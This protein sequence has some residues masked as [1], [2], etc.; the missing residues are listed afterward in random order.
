MPTVFSTN[1]TRIARPDQAVTLGA[2]TEHVALRSANGIEPNGKV[3]RIEPLGDQSFLH[4]DLGETQIVT[5]ADP[6]PAFVQGELVSVR[7]IDPLLFDAEGAR[8]RA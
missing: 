2:R 7:L 1:S 5:L 4:I 3:R 6:D 8:V